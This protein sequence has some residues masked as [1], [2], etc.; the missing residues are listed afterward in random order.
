MCI[1]GF[2]ESAQTLAAPYRPCWRTGNHT[3][4]IIAALGVGRLVARKQMMDVRLHRLSRTKHALGEGVLA[5][6]VVGRSAR[7]G[8]ERSNAARVN[9]G[10]LTRD[11]IEVGIHLVSRGGVAEV[12]CVLV[13]ASGQ[14]CL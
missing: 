13:E 9:A 2:K 14:G 5:V 11:I 8:V 3:K 7:P 1:T 6:K 12:G 10:Y 4:G